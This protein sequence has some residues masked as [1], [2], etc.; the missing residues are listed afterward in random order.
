ME[1]LNLNLDITWAQNKSRT[2]YTP[3]FNLLHIAASAEANVTWDDKRLQLL[4]SRIETLVL[5]AYP[6]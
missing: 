2:I 5:S 6:K 4:S 1:I 3:H